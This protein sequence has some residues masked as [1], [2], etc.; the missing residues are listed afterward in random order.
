MYSFSN[1]C[2][3]SEKYFLEYDKILVIANKQQQMEGLVAFQKWQRE[4]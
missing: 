3:I 4:K 1:L 2:I